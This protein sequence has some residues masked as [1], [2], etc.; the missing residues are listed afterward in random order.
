MRFPVLAG[1]GLGAKSG[2]GPPV[3]H[4]LTLGLH[5]L[6]HKYFK[7]KISPTRFRLWEKQFTKRHFKLTRA[8]WERTPHKTI[9][10]GRHNNSKYSATNIIFYQFFG[11][12]YIEIGSSKK[13]QSGSRMTLNPD[14]DP[15]YGISSYYL[16]KKLKLL[17]NYKTFSSKEVNL[18]IECCKSH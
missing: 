11:S 2:G 18:T 9:W 15:S 14:P 3:W 8:L 12:I 6:Q 10:I 4:P 7:R 17:L 16:K 1:A 13:S 5:L